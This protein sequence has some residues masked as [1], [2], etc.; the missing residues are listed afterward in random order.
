MLVGHVRVETGLVVDAVA[1]QA[2]LRVNF[3]ALL[4]ERGQDGA[5]ALGSV[6][7]LTCRLLLA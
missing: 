2:I 4:F 6:Y 5:A 3:I 1:G 7:Q